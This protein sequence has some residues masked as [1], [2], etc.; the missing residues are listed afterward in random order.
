M[1]THRLRLFAKISRPCF[2]E[3]TCQ[4]LKAT[5]RFLW[6]A[7]WAQWCGAR[8]V[9]AL[10]TLAK[11]LHVEGA[12]YELTLTCAAAC[13][14]WLSEKVSSNYC[15]KQ[16]QAQSTFGRFH[17][18][19]RS[20]QDWVVGRWGGCGTQVQDGSGTFPS[21]CRWSEAID[22]ICNKKR[23][24][25]NSPQSR[26]WFDRF[27]GNWEAPNTCQHCQRAAWQSWCLN[28]FDLIQL[29][30]QR[31]IE[32]A[33]QSGPR[34]RMTNKYQWHDGKT[35]KNLLSLRLS[36]REPQ[37]TFFDV[38]KDVTWR[39]RLAW[40]GCPPIAFSGLKPLLGHPSQMPEPKRSWSPMARE[41]SRVII[42]HNTISCF[43]T[44]LFRTTFVHQGEKRYPCRSWRRAGAGPYWIVAWDMFSE[45]VETHSYKFGLISVTLS[46]IW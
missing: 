25:K 30:K 5:E 3:R 23:P 24:R 35:W 43:K 27:D 8:W 32:P 28:V 34:L 9:K 29:P 26:C 36:S 14:S 33:G 12:G 7:P 10:K 16:W 20:R 18:S 41:P 42:D 15:W 2:G 19:K 4:I 17:L 31:L 37:N 45:V 21:M 44:L 40:K 39:R 22:A 11:S 1:L 38:T 13:V 6:C 46:K